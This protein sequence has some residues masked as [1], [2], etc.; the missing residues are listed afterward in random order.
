MTTRKEILS[1]PAMLAPALGY[2]ALHGVVGFHAMVDEALFYARPKMP[3]RM[4]ADHPKH[5]SFSSW[6][7]LAW[8]LSC[9][10]G[11][12]FWVGLGSITWTYGARCLWIADPSKEQELISARSIAH[13]LTGREDLPN[14]VAGC[15]RAILGWVDIRETVRGTMG[16]DHLMHGIK[17]HHQHCTPMSAPRARLYDIKSCHATLLGRMP[18]PLVTFYGEDEVSFRPLPRVERARWRAATSAMMEHKGLR[19]SFVGNMVGATKGAEPRACYYCKGQRRFGPTIQGPL[20]PA[21][22]LVV[23]TAYELCAE[24]VE[25]TRAIYSNQDCV[26]TEHGEEPPRAWTRHGLRVDLRAEGEAEICSVGVYRVGKKQTKWYEA[27]SRHQ[28]PSV[29][30]S[31]SGVKW[32]QWLDRVRIAA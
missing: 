29:A 12:Q 9:I 7:A 27:G 3:R 16:G 8:E 20:R 23:R 2:L 11:G 15:A 28:T 18:S 13:S 4:P 1:L 24:A 30:V 21:G 31:V 6:A 14:S 26:I 22:L 10:L 5:Q 17:W 32:G 19:N 25:E